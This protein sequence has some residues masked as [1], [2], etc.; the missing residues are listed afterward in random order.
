[1]PSK[2]VLT[3][4]SDGLRKKAN[5]RIVAVSLLFKNISFRRLVR[6][7]CTPIKIFTFH[8]IGS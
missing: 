7:L 2:Y 6:K 5:Y 4:N 1:M 8:W 3:K